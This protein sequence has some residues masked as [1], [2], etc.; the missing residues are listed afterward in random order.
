VANGAEPEGWVELSDAVAALR[1]DLTEAW[2]DGDVPGDFD[3]AV[4]HPERARP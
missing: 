4:S 1:R 3:D 2:W